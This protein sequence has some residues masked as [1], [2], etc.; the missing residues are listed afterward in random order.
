MQLNCRSYTLKGVDDLHVSTSLFKHWLCE[1]VDLL[2]PPEMYNNC[3]VF[4]SDAEVCCAT[5]EQL[6]TA[7]C[8]MVLFIISLQLFLNGCH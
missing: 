6:L 3:I 8:H 2:I 4:A 5:V 1:L 7:N